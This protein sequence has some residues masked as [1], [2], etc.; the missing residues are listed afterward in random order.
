ME[1]NTPD[2]TVNYFAK[3]FLLQFHHKTFVVERRLGD[4]VNELGANYDHSTL[5][6][7]E[8]IYATTRLKPDAD[9]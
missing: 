5:R 1:K 8:R 4:H 2:E 3:L 7:K 6:I 9:V